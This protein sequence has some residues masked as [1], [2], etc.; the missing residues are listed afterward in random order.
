[1]AN[2]KLVQMLVVS[3]GRAISS[4]ARHNLRRH[5]A[6]DRRQPCRSRLTLVFPPL[7]ATDVVKYLQFKAVD[8][9]YV[10]HKDKKIYKARPLPGPG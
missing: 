8:G 1:M 7:Q 3:A 4:R 9:S 6:W 10:M 2:G 5:P